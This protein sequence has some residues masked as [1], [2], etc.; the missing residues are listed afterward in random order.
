MKKFYCGVLLFFYV[1]TF[2][3]HAQAAADSSKIILDKGSVD[4]SLISK[5]DAYNKFK[6]MKN[7]SQGSSSSLGRYYDDITNAADNY[8]EKKEY[9][10]AWDLYQRA[11]Y[12]HNDQ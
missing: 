7:S 1:E 12:S 3:S 6:K 2:I 4:D 8:F 10:K 5:T 9:F 11:F